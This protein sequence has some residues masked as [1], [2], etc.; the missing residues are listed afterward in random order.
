MKPF[1]F[2]LFCSGCTVPSWLVQRAIRVTAP[3]AGA[4]TA[5][6]QAR[7]L[8]LPSSMPSVTG[9][10][11]EPP[12]ADRSTAYTPVAPPMAMPRSGSGAPAF[13]VSPSWTAVKKAR[14]T[15]R[16][17]GTVLNPVSPGLTLACGVS[18]MR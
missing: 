8:Y 13:T 6:C 12:S 14:G 1:G 10:Q 2:Q 11:V 9:I 3:D 4:G 18:G 17:I 16:L 7:K 15:M 5:P